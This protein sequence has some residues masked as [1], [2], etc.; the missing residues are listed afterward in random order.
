MLTALVKKSS[1]NKLS[2]SVRYL[3][4]YFDDSIIKAS[5]RYLAHHSLMNIHSVTILISFD[6]YTP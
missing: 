3:S 6:N 5:D 2:E 1:I 4:T